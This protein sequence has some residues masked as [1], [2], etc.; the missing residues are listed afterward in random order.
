MFICVALALFYGDCLIFLGFARHSLSGTPFGP[1]VYFC[2]ARF[3]AVLN[4]AKTLLLR[5]HHDPVHITWHPKTMSGDYA[6]CFARNMFFDL[7]QVRVIG[8]R[9]YIHKT[10]RSSARKAAVL[11]ARKIIA[12]LR[13]PLPSVQP[14]ISHRASCARWRAPILRC[15]PP[16]S[17]SACSRHRSYVLSLLPL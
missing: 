9:V 13:T 16:V 10:S 3:R 6:R 2:E 14:S 8:H 5:D 7:I 1:P 11:S 17:P 12:Q 15:I 4:N